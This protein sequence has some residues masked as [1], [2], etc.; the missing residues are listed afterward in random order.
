MLPVPVV[1]VIRDTTGRLYHRTEVRSATEA[2]T[3]LHAVR[4]ITGRADLGVA[5][6]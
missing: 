3:I 6:S 2:A 4:T 1:I 5:L